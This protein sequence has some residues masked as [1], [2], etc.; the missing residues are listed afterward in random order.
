VAL[1]QLTPSSNSTPILPCIAKV[2][3]LL[4]AELN[5]YVSG[6]LEQYFTQ[7]GRRS[8]KGEFLIDASPLYFKTPN[9]AEEVLPATQ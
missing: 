2:S 4:T 5:G 6:N 3:H 8:K 7:L 1:P 9:L